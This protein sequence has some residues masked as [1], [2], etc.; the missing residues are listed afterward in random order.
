MGYLTVGKITI[1]C[2]DEAKAVKYIPAVKK[3]LDN[4]AQSQAGSILLKSL[5]VHEK[6][7]TIMPYDNKGDEDNAREAA[8]TIRPADAPK[9]KGPAADSSVVYFS[10]DCGGKCP[11]HTPA[12]QSA[13]LL[14]ERLHHE[15]VH[16]L[17]RISGRYFPLR[18]SG[19]NPPQWGNSEEFLAI[20]MTNIFISDMTNKHK[21]ALRGAWINHPKLAKEYD[22]SFTFFL[23]DPD[24]YNI[25]W[26]FC[27][28]NRGY[29]HMLAR[30]HGRFNPVAAILTNRRKAFEMSVQAME[31]NTWNSIEVSHIVKSMTPLKA[32]R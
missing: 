29:A 12:D 2:W 4:I 17:R 13:T 20:V 8:S 16:S 23:L 18:L 5:A 7:V 1:V 28:E 14:H 24:V 26:R 11:A 22:K 9:Q 25:I 6:S 19:Q 32:T 31:N 27:D 30:V 3:E 21:T 15:L 10:P